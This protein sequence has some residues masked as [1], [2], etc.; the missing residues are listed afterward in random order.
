[1]NLA[2]F[3][4]T[5][6]LIGYF[7]L[8]SPFALA[9]DTGWYGGV[10]VGQSRTNIDDARIST[11]LQSA[12]FATAVTAKDERDTAYKLFG[13]YRFN[14][15]LAF[16]GGYFDLGQSSYTSTTTGP[17][18]TLTGS[19]K[20]QGVNLDAVGV[21]PITDKFSAF[22]RLGLIYA[23][24]KDTFTATGGV[25]VPNPSASKR[26]ANYKIGLGLQYDLNGSIGLRGE[27]ERYRVDD[28]AG[29]RGAVDVY[30]AGMIVKF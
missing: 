4:G 23:E 13:G 19:M 14:R 21:A 17:A 29:N 15:N 25:S 10:N 8:I 20:R 9:A 1:M 16:E 5:L 6:S 7:A 11:E 26:A 2:K 30:S 3:V 18:G 22:G 24:S 28:S 12:G 27:V